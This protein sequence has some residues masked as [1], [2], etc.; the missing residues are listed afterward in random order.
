MGSQESQ[1]ARR[2]T[3]PRRGAGGRRIAFVHP[4]ATAGIL[5]EGASDAAGRAAWVIAGTG[6]NLVSCPDGLGQ[7]DLLG[8][9]HGDC[10]VPG[11]PAP[12]M[13][14]QTMRLDGCTPHGW[15]SDNELARLGK[16]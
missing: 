14:Q 10:K 4:K 7:P 9:P 11:E 5:L 16:G 1:A 6:V 2:T 15:P 3:P 12:V 13:L 8:I